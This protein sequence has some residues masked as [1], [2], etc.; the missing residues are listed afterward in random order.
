MP[1]FLLEVGFEEMPASWLAG[2]GEQAR[3][4]FERLAGEHHL[5]PSWVQ[6]F[7][8]PRRLV[9]AAQ[10]VARQPDREERVW[11]PSLKVA[12]GPDGAWSNAASGFAKKVGST[13]DAPRAR[14][15]RAWWPRCCAASRSPS[16]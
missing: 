11:G 2:V 12:K 14:C 4:V 5:D 1:E 15:C 7:F 3:V 6:S 10:V 9:V 16:G 13:P 8:T